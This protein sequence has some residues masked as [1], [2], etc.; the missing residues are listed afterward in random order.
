MLTTIERAAKDYGIAAIRIH[1][2]IVKCHITRCVE[3][4]APGLRAQIM[5][6][7]DELNRYFSN[8]PKT[9]EAW[10]SDYMDTQNKAI[11]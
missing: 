2:L 1:S 3:Q 6:D 7:T 8:H 9:L 4:P 5:V 10:R 11:K